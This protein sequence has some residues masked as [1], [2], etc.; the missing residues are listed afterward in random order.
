MQL[1]RS[2]LEFEYGQNDVAISP[3]LHKA[4]LEFVCHSKKQALKECYLFSKLGKLLTMDQR[5]LGVD[6]PL[7]QVEQEWGLKK[8]PKPWMFLYHRHRYLG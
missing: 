2:K 3:F 6:N 4:E 1:T 5:T 7:V 8:S